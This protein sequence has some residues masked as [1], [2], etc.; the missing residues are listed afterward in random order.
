MLNIFKRAHPKVLQTD[1]GTQFYNNQFQKL[2]RK[3]NMKHYS[4]YT[5]IKAVKAER[6]IRTF[7]NSIYKHFTATGSRNLY[8]I[9]YNVI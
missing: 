1:N 2:V 5:S 3:Y 8:N 9:N 6:V 7:K 4:T